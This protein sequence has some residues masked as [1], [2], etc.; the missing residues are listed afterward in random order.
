V[1]QIPWKPVDSTFARITSGISLPDGRALR[2]A[3]KRKQR[4][5]AKK[6]AKG[7]IYD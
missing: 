4:K 3:A 1:K 7:E 5:A 2:R 6:Q